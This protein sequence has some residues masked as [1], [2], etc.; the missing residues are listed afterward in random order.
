[1]TVRIKI[2]CLRDEGELEAAVEAG[3]DAVGVVSAMPSGPGTIPDEEIL[4]LVRAAPASVRTVLL[5]S[6]TDPE[7]VVEQV[8][9]AG[10]TDV[11][12]VRAVP[13]ETHEALRS[14][15]PG[16]RVLQV[17]H[18]EGPEAVERARAVATR[19]DA[20]LLDSGSPGAETPEL[21]GTGR[22]HD[23]SVSRDLV[24]A[25]DVPVWLAGGL[26][27]E[28]VAQAV[29]QVR[30]YGVDVCSGL[31]PD[32]RLERVLLESFVAAARGASAGMD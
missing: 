20:I 17:I 25:V 26:N 6:R 11:Q 31:R 9:W 7:P 10:T 8:V 22:V 4:R 32:G 19:V 21:G 29:R 27:P 2:C 3:A 18:V 15:L 13:P 30:P 12:L 23:W 24:Q 28:N 16:V 14:R 1:M 5:T